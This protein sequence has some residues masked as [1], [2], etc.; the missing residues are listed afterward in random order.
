MFSFIRNITTD[1]K[2]PNSLETSA[3]SKKILVELK[4][5]KNQIFTTFLFFEPIN[6]I[7]SYISKQQRLLSCNKSIIC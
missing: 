2:N 3:K 4:K 1:F 7:F 6:A 5:N